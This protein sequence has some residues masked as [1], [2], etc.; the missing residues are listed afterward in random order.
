MGLGTRTFQRLVDF[1]CPRR[2]VMAETV[3]VSYI[4]STTVFTAEIFHP[5]TK[6]HSEEEEAPTT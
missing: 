6:Y 3:T 4:S 2:T 5:R 1:M